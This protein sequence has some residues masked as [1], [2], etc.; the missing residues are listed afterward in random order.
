MPVEL[1]RRTLVARGAAGMAFALLGRAVP[2]RGDAPETQIFSLEAGAIAAA[3]TTLLRAP[4]R[5]DL[6]G[7]AWEGPRTLQGDLRVRRDGDRWSP[8]HPVP[9]N[10]HAREAGRADR[11]TD[12]VWVGGADALELR[13]RQGVRR[14]EA[15]FVN[16]SGTATSAGRR[17]SALRRALARDARLPSVQPAPGA[18]PIIP[19]SA[20]AGRAGRP[21]APPL[22]GEVALGVVHHTES[23]NGYG[24]GD[25]AAMVL[26]IARYHRDVR[27]WDDIGYN[28]LVDRF[29]QIFEGRAGGVLEAVAGAHAGGFNQSS[30]GAAILGS[31]TGAPPGS[32]ATNALARLLAWKLTYHGAPTSGRVVVPDRGTTPD[33]YHPGDSVRLPRIAGHR[34]L[35]ATD[36]PGGELYR[37]LPQLR[38]LIGRLAAGQPRAN[39]PSPGVTAAASVVRRGA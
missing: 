33:K 7:F 32:R 17:R 15:H 31:F 29:G 26:A 22:Y 12:P 10:G 36:C 2:A 14:L 8:W 13:L 34:D 11:V 6:L 20:W 3:H 1:T 30:T 4:A 5:F 24:P 38:R 21:S 16:S 19:R 35:N 23:L 18:P 39:G 37:R 9:S 25:S 28:F 27:H